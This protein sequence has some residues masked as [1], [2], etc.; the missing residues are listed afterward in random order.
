MRLSCIL[1]RVYGFNVDLFVKL[2]C[3][4]KLLLALLDAYGQL[5]LPIVCL[6]SYHC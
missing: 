4:A 2:V 6:L 5:Y 3:L 1:G